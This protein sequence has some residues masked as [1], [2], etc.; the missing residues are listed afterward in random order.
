METGVEPPPPHAR[1]RREV[2][3]RLAARGPARRSARRVAA[4]ADARLRPQRRRAARGGHAAIAARPRRRLVLDAPAPRAV[5]RVS[6]IDSRCRRTRHPNRA[7]RA[8][9]RATRGSATRRRRCG[10]FSD[11]LGVSAVRPAHRDHR[12]LGAVAVRVRRAHRV[13]PAPIVRW[14]AERP[15]GT[16]RMPRGLAVIICY[17]VFIAALTGLHVPAR[18]A[19]VARHRAAR[20]GS[21]GALQAHQRGVHARARALARGAV[22]VAA[23]GS[24]AARGA[25]D[26]ARGAAAARH[27]VHDDAAARRPV[28]DAA[29]AERRRHQDR[30]RR[31]LP[32]A[33]RRRAAGAGS[34]SRT[35]CAHTSSTRSSACRASST[36]SRA[37]CRT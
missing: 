17:I 12:P 27:R 22:P 20:Q 15:N 29:R 18:A 16:R 11:A 10:R 1:E 25:A 36:T 33:G 31:R 37:C 5:G 8:C 9:V 28:R 21:A 32:R 34:R 7:R 30:A 13:H 6:G 14:M 19:A 24:H 23:A 26:R 4:G 35:S 2:A 3:A